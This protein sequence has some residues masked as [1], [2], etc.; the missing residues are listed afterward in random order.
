LST[1]T[2]S[3]V[4]Q[5]LRWHIAGTSTDQIVTTVRTFPARVRKVLSDGNTAAI[6][7]GVRVGRKNE[8]CRRHSSR[9]ASKTTNSGTIC[10]PLERNRRE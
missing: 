10:R 1:Q 5:K 9:G 8:T 6:A 4:H 3:V 2:F 7:T